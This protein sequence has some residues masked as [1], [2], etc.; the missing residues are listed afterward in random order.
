MTEG[1][2]AFIALS[3]GSLPPPRTWEEATRK[4]WQTTE[5][6]RQRITG[7]SSPTTRGGRRCSAVL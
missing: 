4:Q 6:W 2:Q 1:E 5:F 3:W 7:A